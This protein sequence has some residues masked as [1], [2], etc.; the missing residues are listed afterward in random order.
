MPQGQGKQEDCQHPNPRRALES[1]SFSPVLQRSSLPEGSGGFLWSRTVV[2]LS[3][4]PSPSEEEGE[5]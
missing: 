5:A 4:A 2:V 3:H 1:D